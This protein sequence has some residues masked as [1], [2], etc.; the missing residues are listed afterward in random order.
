MYCMHAQKRASEAPRT[1][2]RAC[3]ISKF[4]GG[5]PPDPLH[6]SAPHLYLP[7][8][9][10]IL[11]VAL[12]TADLRDIVSPSTLRAFLPPLNHRGF[13]LIPVARAFISLFN[14]RAFAFLSP[15]IPPHLAFQ[16]S[17][18]LQLLTAGVSG[19]MSVLISCKT[20]ANQ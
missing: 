16:P 14:P 20:I 8:D 1:H 12:I 9:P 19:G 13:I 18:L 17:W 11:S 10:T 15:L 7:R 4:P 2:L 3:K 6:L 5:V